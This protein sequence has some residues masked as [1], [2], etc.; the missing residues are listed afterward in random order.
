MPLVA[1]KKPGDNFYPQYNVVVREPVSNITITKGRLYTKDSNGN[2]V[3][4]TSASGFIR[5]IFQASRSIT[6][7]GTAGEH[8]VD[9]FTHRSRIG[10]AAAADLAEGALVKY[11]FTS[12]QVE[13]FTGAANLTTVQ[14]TQTVGRIYKIYSRD[15]ITSEKKT[16]DAGD[17]VIVDLGAG[18]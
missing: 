11:N 14:L 17:I 16:T 8:S 15:S 10:L 12:N 9:C 7:A 3:A 1:N 2:L 4:A 6:A 13:L 5:G 18:L